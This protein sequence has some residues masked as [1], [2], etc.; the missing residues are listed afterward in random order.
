MDNIRLKIINYQSL[1]DIKIEKNH[2]DF[3]I[4]SEYLSESV[5][6]ALLSNPNIKDYSKSLM[7]LVLFNEAI[8]GRF[9][10]MPTRIKNGDS[11]LLAQTG[12]GIEISRE[13]RGKGLGKKLMSDTIFYSEYPIYIGQLYS[14]GASAI[15]NKLG[16][17][18]FEKPLYVKLCKTRSV[19]AAKGQGGIKLKLYSLLGDLKIKIRDL[20][21]KRK[22][23]SLKKK[24]IIK[25]EYSV[26]E[27][28]DNIT[29]NDGHRYSEI[30]DRTWLQWNLDN[31]FTEA[32]GDS[33]SF[34]AVYE[35]NGLPIGFFMI[36]ER[37][38]ENPL[39]LFKNL[40]R[41][42][43]VE[44]GSANEK[45]FTEA[46]INLMAL[47]MFSS[48]VDKI[49]TVISSE[50]L[51]DAIKQIG[52]EYRGQYQMALKTTEDV[53]K[54]ILDQNNWRIRYGGANT[55]LV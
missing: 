8:V 36:K 7:N 2:D 3:G 51:D 54:T 21:N 52:F 23:C 26:P 4:V 17:T 22:L 16:L 5:Q 47:S 12:G 37:F 29:L 43:V 30:H 28:V 48:N 45:K 38:E 11:I 53:D 41:G 20:P 50:G 33:N 55:I 14:S 13:F 10:M 34:Y 19:Y 27:W 15:I 42:T 6:K 44:W 31:R 39:G 35:K 46:D 32:N 40:V 18:I 24:Y 9:M 25:K 49:N 1:V